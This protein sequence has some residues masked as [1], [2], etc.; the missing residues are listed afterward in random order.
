[1]T[2]KELLDRLPYE[3]ATTGYELWCA[4]V[5]AVFALKMAHFS[6]YP[7][8]S[9]ATRKAMIAQHRRDA[10]AIADELFT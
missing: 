4:T 1:M 9:P 5:A 6:G 7:N 8:D 3:K 2:T 10:V